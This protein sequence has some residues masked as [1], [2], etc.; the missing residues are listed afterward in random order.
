MDAL[1]YRMLKLLS[2]L[3]LIAM[4]PLSA[5]LLNWGVKG[6]VS[7]HN[8]IRASGIFSSDPPH[9]TVGPMAELNLP[10]GLGIEVDGLYRIIDYS[11]ESRHGGLRSYNT[12]TI[13][14]LAKYRLPA[15]LKPLYL[16]AGLAVRFLQ[17]LPIPSTSVGVVAGAGTRHKAKFLWISPELRYTRWNNDLFHTSFNGGILHTRKDQMELLIGVTF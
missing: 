3:I 16:D 9:W 1:C 4:T 11:T 2:A 6:G 17:R 15:R 8:P 13:P 10:A 12:W 5:Q 7:L 14:V